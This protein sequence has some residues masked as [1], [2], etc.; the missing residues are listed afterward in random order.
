L[1]DSLLSL[2]FVYCVGVCKC[3]YVHIAP[4]R[5]SLAL[6][7]LQSFHGLRACPQRPQ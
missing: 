1:G 3:T 5:K 2:V 6:V 4:N 7:V